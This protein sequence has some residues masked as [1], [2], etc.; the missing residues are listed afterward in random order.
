MKW[1]RYEAGE[2]SGDSDRLEGV[3]PVYDENSLLDS[4]NGAILDY[5]PGGHIS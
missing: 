4:G 2:S 5:S 1:T 3:C